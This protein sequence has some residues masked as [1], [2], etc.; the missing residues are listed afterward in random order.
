[1]SDKITTTIRIDAAIWRDVKTE[2]DRRGQTITVFVTR[3]LK[4]AVG[5]E[6]DEYISPATQFEKMF[7]GH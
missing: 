1:M 7:E 3:A 6:A 5:S 4:A 2:A